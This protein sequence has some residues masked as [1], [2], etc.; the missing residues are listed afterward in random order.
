M[1]VIDSNLF[2]WLPDNISFVGD[3]SVLEHEMQ[4]QGVRRLDYVGAQWGFHMKSVRT[5]RTLWFRR[6]QEHVDA[7]G[8]LKY[9]EFEAQLTPVRPIKLKVFND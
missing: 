1:L 6:I 4:R 7:D 3:A 9:V 8:D 5:G 2:T